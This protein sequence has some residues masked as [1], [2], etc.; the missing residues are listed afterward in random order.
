MTARK[1]GTD[2]I[3]TKLIRKE[4]MKMAEQKF[5]KEVVSDSYSDTISKYDFVAENEITVTITLAE[6]REL[7]GVK[8]TC[9]RKIKEA[10]DKRIEY[11]SKANTLEKENSDLK[12]ELYDLQKKL[13]DMKSAVKEVS[14]S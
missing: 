14:E 3:S 13:E 8:A 9:D 11:Y 4:E 10:D 12:K 1:T 6:Y 7:I 2:T 5:K